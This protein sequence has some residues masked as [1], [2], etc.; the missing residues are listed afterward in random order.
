MA[1]IWQPGGGGGTLQWIKQGTRL[2]HFVVE[3]IKAGSITYIGGGTKQEMK[4]QHKPAQGI[5]VREHITGPGRASN[6]PKAPKS[7]ALNSKP[8]LAEA[9]KEEEAA[10]K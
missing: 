2:G 3:E 9:G 5:L 10:P 7:V 4:V 1:L 6:G 8:L